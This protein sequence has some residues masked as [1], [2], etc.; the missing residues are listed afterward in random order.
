MRAWMSLQNRVSQFLCSDVSELSTKLALKNSISESVFIF[1][2]LEYRTF[3]WPQKI[4]ALRA[5]FW[6][7]S[8]RSILVLHKIFNADSASAT[9]DWELDF[10]IGSPCCCP[11]Q[12]EKNC[13]LDPLTV[14]SSTLEMDLGGQFQHYF[15]LLFHPMQIPHFFYDNLKKLQKALWNASVDYFFSRSAY[16]TFFEKVRYIPHF[17]NT[18]VYASIQP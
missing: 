2:F 14:K 16:R 7:G 17:I 10:Q 13:G 9:S 4:F 18:A 6:R 12:A 15:R 3:F 1:C 11:P 8:L 5:N